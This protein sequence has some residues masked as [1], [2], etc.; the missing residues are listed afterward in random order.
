MNHE[1]SPRRSAAAGEQP[2]HHP[3]G[4]AEAL[5]RAAAA[6]RDS[7]V[8]FVL[9][10]SLACWVR[11][12][13]DLVTKDVD[14]CLK[15]GDA[16]RALEALAE[17]GMPTERPPEGW[18]YKAWHD[19]IL[20]DLLFAPADVP[21]TDEVLERADESDVDPGALPAPHPRGMES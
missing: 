3:A 9:C 21:V 8:P 19:D 17:A 4:L 18:L 13:P 12:G 15:P 11:G 16:D 20:V 2:E 14:F 6:L 7:G 10:G 5:K 1:P